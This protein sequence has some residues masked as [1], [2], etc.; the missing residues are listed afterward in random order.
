MYVIDVTYQGCGKHL[1]LSV[2]ALFCRNL[3]TDGTLEI[4]RNLLC[5]LMG[6]MGAEKG[7]H[8]EQ[9]EEER[10]DTRVRMCAVVEGVP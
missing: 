7:L 1:L 9:R 5:S 3:R 10:I 4:S 2:S 6:A 8:L